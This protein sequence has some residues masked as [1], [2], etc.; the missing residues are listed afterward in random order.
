MGGEGCGREEGVERMSIHSE[1][2][3]KNSHSIDRER[4]RERE[5]EERKRD[6]KKTGRFIRSIYNHFSRL[7]DGS[8]EEISN[9]KLD[10]KSNWK[11]SKITLS[12]SGNNSR[13]Y[14]IKDDAVG[15]RRFH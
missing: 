3:N 2:C 11:K 1:T 15:S 4:E 8:S 10:R 13:M 9:R 6:G 14:A 5:R 12:K 7:P